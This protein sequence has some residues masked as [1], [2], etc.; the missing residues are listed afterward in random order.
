MRRDASRVA[1]PSIALLL[2]AAILLASCAHEVVPPSGVARSPEAESDEVRLWAQAGR[3]EAELEKRVA[4]YENEVLDQ[5]LTRLGAA[6]TPDDA[7]APGHPSLTFV[8][9]PDPT[10]NAFAMPNGRIYVHTG[11]LACLENEAQLAMILAREIAHVT[12]RHALRL[13]R[14]GSSEGDL[15]KLGTAPLSPTA[16][17]ILGHRL[18]LAATAAISGYGRDSEREAD[19]DGTASLT[20]AGY[21]LTEAPKLYA[22]LQK[23]AKERGGLE[24]FFLGNPE[25]LAE[26]VEDTSAA[27]PAGYVPPAGRS[28]VD[29]QE[30]RMRMRTVVRENARL[31]IQAER[32]GLAA[33]QLDRV[34]ALTPRDSIAELYYGDLYRLESQRADDPVDRADDERKAVERYDR[35]ATLDPAYADPFRQLGFLY[36]QQKDNARARTAFER[37]LALKPDAPDAQRIKE[38]LAE[39]DRQD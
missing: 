16:T 35:A 5:Y 33:A 32:F 30:F 10:L 13:V 22:L 38:Y 36:Y 7:R 39:L 15:F 4:P 29:V 25:R 26:R 6:S 2:A 14:D 20:R 28:V 3:E 23:A 11:L 21:D 19:V 34:L 17:V 31:D 18:E 1:S 12:E 27:I 37:Y 8:V 24:T 9:L